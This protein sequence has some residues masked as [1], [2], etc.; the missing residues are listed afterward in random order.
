[1]EDGSGTTTLTSDPW[2][3]LPCAHSTGSAEVTRPAKD[4]NF[5]A[6]DE[7]GTGLGS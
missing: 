7:L 2:D 1:M 5:K 3:P 6:N 4:A